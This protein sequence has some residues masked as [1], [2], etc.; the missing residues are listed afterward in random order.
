MV[1]LDVM[2][3]ACNFSYLGGGGWRISSAKLWGD[4][5]SQIKTKVPR[6]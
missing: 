3:H 6:A 4:L 2:V 5:V 1:V